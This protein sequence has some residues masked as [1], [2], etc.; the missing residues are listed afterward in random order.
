MLD[1]TLEFL[2]MSGMEL[3]LAVMV[4]VPEPWMN[5]PNLSR[6][7]RD[8]YQ[9]Y[10]AMMEP[11]DGP[12]AILFSDGDLVGAVLDRNGL[13]PARY[14]L[15]DDG[16]LILSSEVGVL[17]IDPAHILRRSRLEPGKMLLADTVQGRVIGDEE[18]KE[19][20]AARSPYGEWLD[21]GLLQ[22]KDLPIPNH[23]VET[24]PPERLAQ[25]QKAFGYTWEDVK[26]AILPM[27]RTGAEPTAAMGADI[28]LAVLDRRDRPLF[29]YF[30]QRFA[31]VTNPPID[32][33]RE[34]IVTDTAVYVGDDGD[35]LE[36]RAENCRVLQ[37]HNPILTSVDMLKIKH[38]DRPGF[39]VETVS[40]LYF[41]NMPLK[42]ALDQ[43]KLSADRAYRGGANIII[44]I[45]RAHV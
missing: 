25:V 33:I 17:D 37:I 44:Q 5:D 2:V 28:P 41:K 24:C 42:R 13:R 38:M 16:R 39:R 29:D 11:W 3:P 6:A 35:L 10:A 1:N 8:L 21:R 26:D 4:C 7:R 20:C 14:S 32:A 43:M 9:Y 23:R 15:T 34:E 30:R 12:A 19:G 22:L 31:Q 40:L 27:A 18:L 45:G 36:E